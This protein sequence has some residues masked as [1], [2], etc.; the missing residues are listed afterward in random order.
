MAKNARGLE[1]F[2]CRFCNGNEYRRE[3]DWC[4]CSSCSVFF[5]DPKA[6]SLSPKQKAHREIIRV[7]IEKLAHKYSIIG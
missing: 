4:Y 5:R 3:K 7:K 2:C 6:F 1:D